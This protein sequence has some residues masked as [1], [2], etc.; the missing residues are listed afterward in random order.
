M[1]I[2]V[3]NATDAAKGAA[4]VV[5]LD[6]GLAPIIKLIKVGRMIHQRIVTWIINKIVKT[7]QSVVL[8]VIAFLIWKVFIIS[9]F[10]MILLMFLVDFV[11]I[12]LATDNARPSRHP[13]DWNMKQL[14]S[15][16]VLIGILTFGESLVLLYVAIEVMGLGTVEVNTIQTFG[17]EVLFF[18]G[19]TT[20]YIL[21]ER[22]F[23]WRSRPSWSL[24]IVGV[25]DSIFVILCST[26]GISIGKLKISSLFISESLFFFF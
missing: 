19:L 9:A 18:Y 3:S 8:V 1:G 14:V 26:F 6:E 22:S 7:F 21:R 12:S 20:I 23:F 2:A 10:E 15:I 5:F 17:F 25:I 11:T 24:I 13:E 16:G 4:S